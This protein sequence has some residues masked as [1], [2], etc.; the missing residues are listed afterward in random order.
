LRR[1]VVN[2][3]D[4]ASVERAVMDFLRLDPGFLFLCRLGAGAEPGVLI[5]VL[6]PTGQL[7]GL[8]VKAADDAG[9]DVQAACFDV[10]RAFGAHAAVVSSIDEARCEIEKVRA[11]QGA[12]QDVA[13]CERFLQLAGYDAV[14]LGIDPPDV[15]HIECAADATPSCR[16]KTQELV[17]VVRAIFSAEPRQQ[18]HS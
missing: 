18:L 14:A 6:H 5:G 3:G 2:E 17:A 11:L 1:F 4:V 7:V 10:W 12:V 15:E 9:S 8:S 16:S 13:A